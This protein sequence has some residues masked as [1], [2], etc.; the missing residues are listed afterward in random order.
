MTHL[1]MLMVGLIAYSQAPGNDNAPAKTG[2]ISDQ[3]WHDGQ[4]KKT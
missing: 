4:Q 1:I 2:A 3:D